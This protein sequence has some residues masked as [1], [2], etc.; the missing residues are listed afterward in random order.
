MRANINPVIDVAF[1]TNVSLPLILC[2]G[3]KRESVILEL[4]KDQFTKRSDPGG[5]QLVVNS[6]PFLLCSSTDQTDVTINELCQAQ[7][8]QTQLTCWFPLGRFGGFGN[9]EEIARD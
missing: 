4:E 1:I 7:F 9:F 2:E 6:F 8:A 5:G 3:N